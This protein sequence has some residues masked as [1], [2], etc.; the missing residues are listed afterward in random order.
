MWVI[1]I[2]KFAEGAWIVVLLIPSIVLLFVGIHHHYVNT[3]KQLSLQGLMPPPELRN[4]VIVPISTL[5][6]GTINALK[7][8]NAIAPGNVTAVHISMDPEQT[9]KLQER[10][11]TWGG[12]IPLVMLDSP[13][14]SLVRPLLGYIE[15]VDAALGSRRYHDRPARVRTGQMVAPPAA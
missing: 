14:R 10:W 15:E 8:A 6:R 2:A 9:R 3:A 1:I 13:Y 4:T 11:P 7:Y 5:H 12:D